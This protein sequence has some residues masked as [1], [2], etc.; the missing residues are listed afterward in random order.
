MNLFGFKPL[1]KC[2]MKAT[3][4]YTFL[5]ICLT[6]SACKKED[7]GVGTF[8]AKVI[9][10]S[11]GCGPPLIYFEEKDISA[12]ERI[13]DSYNGLKAWV[14]YNLN[15]SAIREG[16]TL[17]VTI[18]KEEGNICIHPGPSYPHLFVIKFEVN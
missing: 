1:D 12:V 5:A 17:T 15:S 2:I 14:A 10:V 13:T 16:Q 11:S 18:R 9:S 4:F 7:L 6:I 3:V 8:Q